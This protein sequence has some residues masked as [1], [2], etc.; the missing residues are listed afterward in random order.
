MRAF[1]REIRP[2]MISNKEP[3]DRREIP[4]H[5]PA[6]PANSFTSSKSGYSS[7]SAISVNV[8]SAKES[9]TSTLLLF[10]LGQ[11]L[12]PKEHK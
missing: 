6:N 3:S 12:E 4:K 9:L 5:I 2:L 10:L 7:I 8:D 1:L 11:K